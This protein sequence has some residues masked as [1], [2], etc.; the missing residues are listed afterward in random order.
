MV[1]GVLISDPHCIRRMVFCEMRR[2]CT[3]SSHQAIPFDKKKLITSAANAPG[4]FAASVTRKGPIQPGKIRKPDHSSTP[5]DLQFST[6]MG[7]A[8]RGAV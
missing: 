5:H 8:G 2:R 4:S 3:A 7:G 6:N 1:T